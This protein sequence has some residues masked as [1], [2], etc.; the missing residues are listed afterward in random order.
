VGM[1]ER[2]R[3]IQGASVRQRHDV[4]QELPGRQTGYRRGMGEREGRGEER[5]RERERHTSVP[6]A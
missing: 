1:R 2:E 5:E 6:A 3:E 4:T